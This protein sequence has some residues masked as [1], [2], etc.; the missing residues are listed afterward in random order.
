MMAYKNT[1]AYKESLSYWV[2]KYTHE[3]PAINLPFDH[4]RAAQR[5][6]ASSRKDIRIEEDTIK[7]IKL[8]GQS[9]NTSMVDVLIAL[10]EVYLHKLTGQ[11]E[12]VFGLTT[13]GKL[14]R[15]STRLNSSQ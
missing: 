11:Q 4:P 3:I 12:L 1:I 14:D 15:K 6:H 2:E 7:K 9:T 13:S 10:F 8:L 5:S